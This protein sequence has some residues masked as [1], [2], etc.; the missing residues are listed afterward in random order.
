MNIK[1]I[2]AFL[3]LALASLAC[4]FELPK[5]PE[6]GPEVTEKISVST[7]DSDN[8]N[9]KLAFGAGEM[10][11]APGAEK[12][13]EGT[14]TYNYPAFKPAVKT[15]GSNVEV[16]MGEVDF[17]VFP[18]FKGLKNI[19]DLKLGDTPMNLTIEAGAYKGFFELGGLALNNLTIKDGAA[20]VELAFS[21][22]NPAKMSVLHYETGASNVKMI[23]LANANF[24]LM[25]FSS[26]AGDYTLDFSGDLQRDASISISSGLSNLI[27]IVP[28]GVNAVVTIDSGASNISAGS[29]WEQNGKIYTQK[30]QGPTLTFVI[31]IGAGNV[32]LTR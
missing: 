21:E 7:P 14:A 30:G 19:W 24:D 6:P 4:G 9:L 17:N 29:G 20:E 18:T 10:T 32:T 31:N 26:G 8:V 23:G 16:K 27:I 28:E 2:S 12:F 5:A 15:N 22:P 25:D 3:V 1:I 11:L 13:V